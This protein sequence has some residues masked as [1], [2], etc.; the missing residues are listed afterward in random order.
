[1]STFAGFPP[2]AIEFLRELEDNNDRDWFKANRA[3]YDEHLIAP[4]H[5]LA[6]TLSHLGEAR[7]FRPYN[8]TR[9]HPRPPIKE[10]VGIVL[11]GTQLYGGVYYF[12][13]SLDGFFVAAGQHQPATD[14]LE[15]F[16]A[17]VDNPKRIAGFDS[18]LAHA[19]SA[20]LELHPPALKRAPRGYPNDH[21]RIE[22]LRLKDLTVTA[23][24]E[25]GD[26]LHT[27]EC[28]ERVRKQLDA[29]AP[30]VSWLGEHVGPT[31]QQ[32]R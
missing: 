29:A 25:L 24:H 4:A 2:E 11:R 21:P 23:E 27:P 14:Q 20:G 28:G 8:D 13:I 19:E 6:E 5:A 22:L 31:Q 18:A 26:W 1:M 7:G 17:L 3:R 30:L 16:R 12:Q 15:R 9:F 32:R 10:Q